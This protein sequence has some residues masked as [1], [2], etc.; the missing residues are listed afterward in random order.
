MYIDLLVVACSTIKFKYSVMSVESVPG[1]PKLR[2]I[3]LAWLLIIE[4]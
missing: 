4:P 2:I 3:E 1:R